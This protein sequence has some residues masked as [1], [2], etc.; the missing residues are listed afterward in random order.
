MRSDAQTSNILSGSPRTSKFCLIHSVFDSLSQVWS[1]RTTL[2]ANFKP[3]FSTMWTVLIVILPFRFSKQR[4]NDNL[5]RRTERGLGGWCKLDH[6]PVWPWPAQGS[7]RQ[8][9]RRFRLIE[10]SSFCGWWEWP[11][12]IVTGAWLVG[13]R[14]FMFYQS[15]LLLF[16]FFFLST[17]AT[18][19][20][21]IAGNF[22]Q[23]FNFVTFIKAIFWLN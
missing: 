19:E 3:K 4:S 1:R 13:I 22:R 9:R 20:Y 14:P 5:L 18:F 12:V 7:L 2:M 15:C 23:E 16:L 8:S 11:L 21:S 17:I 6:N 10:K